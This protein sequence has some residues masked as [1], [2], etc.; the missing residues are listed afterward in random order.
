MIRVELDEAA[1]PVDWTFLYCND[2]LAALEGY[3]KDKLL[4]QR[5]FQL[6]PDGARKWLK[7][8]YEAAYEKRAAAFDSISEEIGQ[9]L[10][11]DCIPPGRAGAVRLPAPQHPAGE[12]VPASAGRGAARGAA[13]NRGNEPRPPGQHGLP[14]ADGAV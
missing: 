7:P 9:Y 5:F 2:A 8:Y 13:H 14:A 6:F 12:R 3:P 11:I 1:A 10:H 4:G